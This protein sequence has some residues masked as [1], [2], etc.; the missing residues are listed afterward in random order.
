MNQRSK[1]RVMH[2]NIGS[3]EDWTVLFH[4]ESS[5]VVKSFEQ[6]YD[7]NAARRAVLVDP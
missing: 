3:S 4:L 5:V 1:F 2:R 7:P 6:D